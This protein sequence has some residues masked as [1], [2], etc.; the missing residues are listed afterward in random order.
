[1]QVGRIIPLIGQRG[2]NRD[3][4][5]EEYTG[6][7]LVVGEVWDSDYDFFADPQCLLEDKVGF[8]Y[9]LQRLVEDHVIE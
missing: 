8:L 2:S 3:P 1:M 9:L 5:T 7:D 4:A 6:S